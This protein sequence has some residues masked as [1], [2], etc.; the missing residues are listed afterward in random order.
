MAP[1]ERVEVNLFNVPLPRLLVDA[2]HGS[3]S[4]FQL[5]TATVVLPDGS[6]GTGYTYTGGRGGHAIAAVL[7]HDLSPGLIGKNGL[8]I[9]GIVDWM[10]WHV[11]Y[12]GRGGITAFAAS[13]VDIALWDIA[14]KRA[15]L[16]LWKLAGGASNSCRT[17][18]GGIDLAYTL[19]ELLESVDQKLDQGFRGI[20]IKVGRPDLE[21]DLLRAS[22]VRKQIGDDI[23]FMVDANYSMSVDQAI[24]AARR[25][26][27]LG[28]LWFEE[29]TLPDDYQGFA[30]IAEA[31]G[32]P[33][34]M[35]ENLHTL[36]EFGY[37][38][39]QAKLSFIQPDASNCGG[40]S[41]WLRVASMSAERG[42]PVCS[43]GMHELHASL[44]A[45]QSHGGWMEWHSFP[46][47]EYTLDPLR[48]RDGRAIA[49]SVPGVGVEFDWE[50]LAPYR[51]SQACITQPSSG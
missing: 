6:E 51:T 40:I 1:I 29:P 7:E 18:F 20:K 38:F 28:V 32:V 45:S 44:V 10:E 34:A 35:G 17:Y 4:H 31:T 41:A 43:H 15:Q 27:D 11:H 13:A 24:L 12:V 9:P 3:H 23:P 2:K 39:D 42:I 30:R 21:D 47:H 26:A 49:S 50:K 8:D 25:F 14:A 16:P 22:A 19:D 5:V 46:I 48:L 33:L 37:A 36:H